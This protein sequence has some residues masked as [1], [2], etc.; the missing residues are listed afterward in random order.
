MPRSKKAVASQAEAPAMAEAPENEPLDLSTLSG[1]KHGTATNVLLNSAVN[2]V[3]PAEHPHREAL[4]GSV[5]GA[6]AGIAPRDTIEGLLAS[7]I[8]ALHHGALDLLAR[9]QLAGDTDIASRLRRDAR[10]ALQAF[11]AALSALQA[12]RNGGVAQQRVVVER[13][14]VQ[15]GANLAIGAGIAEPPHG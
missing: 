7:H 4:T 12:W 8:A 13:V 2:A 9:A 6:M 11:N 15:E 3:A 10:G 14:L 5:L 1:T